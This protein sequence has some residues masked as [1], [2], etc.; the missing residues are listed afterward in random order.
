MGQQGLE[1]DQV[2]A[3]HQEVVGVGRAHGAVLVLFQ[4]VE[5]DVPVVVDDGVFADPVEGGHGALGVARGAL[6]RGGAVAKR[7]RSDIHKI[8]VGGGASNRS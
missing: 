5:G 2:V 7:A 3:L 8:G 6:G 1:G 4:Q